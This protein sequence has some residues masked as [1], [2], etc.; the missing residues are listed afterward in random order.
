MCRL[1]LR[2]E[3]V[4]TST[5]EK[6]AD[7]DQYCRRAVNSVRNPLARRPPLSRDF[8]RPGLR[9]IDPDM[10]TLGVPRTAIH[11]HFQV[12]RATGEDI[13]M[14]QAN[15]SFSTWYIAVRIRGGEVDEVAVLKP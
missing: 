3:A 5:P 14:D 7:N 2:S 9:A 6:Y 12:P 15:V 1:I 10:A 13:W 4:L 8:R 11:T